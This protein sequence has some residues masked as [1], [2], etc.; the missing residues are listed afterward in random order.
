[1]WKV[2]LLQ[3]SS[4]AAVALV[5]GMWAG[6]PA[7]SSAALGGLVYVLPSVLFVLRLKVAATSGRAS[8]ATFLLWELLKLMLIIGLMAAVARHY[9]DLRW[10]ALLAGLF[11]ALMANLFALLLRI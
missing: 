10:L 8:G 6:W 7:A 5:A 11:A 4:T 2:I 1:M 3:L 9:A